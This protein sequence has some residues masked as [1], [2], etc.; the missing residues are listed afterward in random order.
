MTFT[1][2]TARV[3]SGA[4]ARSDAIPSPEALI[5]RAIELRP[6]LRAQQDAAE[7]RGYY[8]EEVHEEF[9]KAG[10][11]RVL[12]PKRFGGFEYDYPTFFKLAIEVAAGHPSAGWCYCLGASHAPLIAGHWSEEAQQ[13][14]FGDGHFIA[15][16]RAAPGGSCTPVEG[17]YIIDGVYAYSSGIPYA[18]HFIGA[19]FLPN[20]NNPNGPPRVMN[21]VVPKGQ[22]TILNDWGGDKTFGMRAS[23]SNSVRLE[24]VFVPSNMMTD[25]LYTFRPPLPGEPGEGPRVHDNPMYVGTLVAPYHAA[26]SSMAIGAARAAL[27]EFHDIIVSQ[28]TIWPPVMKRSD[29]D[30]FQRPYGEAM[31]MTDAAEGIV[32]QAMTRYMELCRR[33]GAGGAAPTS[34]EQLRLWAMQQ[35]AG[36]LACEAVELLFRSSGSTAAR[37]GSRMLRYL[38]DAGMYRGHVSSQYQV[39][40]HMAAKVRLGHPAGFGEF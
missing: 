8:S 24:K 15:P 37:R 39:V 30:I 14:I 7:E 35:Q 33:W 40:S 1:A 12:Q 31:A 2:S 20:L 4:A 22:Y 16:H 23:G 34:E 17:G 5:Q 19:T 25:S 21:F 11:Y 28:N 18:T 3:V 13:E 6:L 9:R 26:L 32:I 38:G 27:D 36:K 10:F 29:S